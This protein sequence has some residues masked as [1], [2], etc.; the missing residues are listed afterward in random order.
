MKIKD[1]KIDLA[2]ANE[3]L[4]KMDEVMARVIPLVG[5][6]RLRPQRP[7]FFVLCDAIISQ[8]LSIKAAATIVSR[9]QALYDPD[10]YPSPNTV[11]ATRDERLRECGI[12]E[13]KVKYIK[14]LAAKLVHKQINLSRLANFSDEEI[15]EQ[16]T[17]V[18]GIGR[19]T[20]EMFL[21]FSLNRLN[22]LPV[23]DLGL[24]RAVQIE[25]QLDHLPSPAILIEVGKAW[26]PY[27]SVATWYL[28][29][30]L[31]LDKK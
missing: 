23:A 12:S 13:A 1:L 29:Q 31:K 8:Q 9:F 24:Q 6:C 10:K 4:V 19:W 5:S 27:R 14:D 28:W 2:K 15:I 7:Y 11:L 17:K 26:H 18:K 30:S 25:Y 21:I 3:H 22:I 16:L 20:A